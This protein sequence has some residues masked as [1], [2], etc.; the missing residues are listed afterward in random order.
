MGPTMRQ[1]LLKIL[2][3]AVPCGPGSLRYYEARA[4]SQRESSRQTPAAH[5]SDSR[6]RGTLFRIVTPPFREHF[7]HHKNCDWVARRRK[8]TPLHMRAVRNRND[9]GGG[10]RVARTSRPRDSVALASFRL[11]LSLRVS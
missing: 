11:G 4:C 3:P 5:P 1:E 7:S 9:L 6:G 8:K 2:A 10:L